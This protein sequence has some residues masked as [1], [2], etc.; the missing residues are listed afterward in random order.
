MT[1]D[2]RN[3]FETEAPS[4]GNTRRVE[5]SSVLMLGVVN[6]IGAGPSLL[7]RQE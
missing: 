3:E 2:N 4:T 7:F 5:A 6:E 1:D